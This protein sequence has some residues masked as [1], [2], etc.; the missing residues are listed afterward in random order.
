MAAADTNIVIT[1]FSQ[2]GEITWTGSNMEYYAVQYAPSV[3][4]TWTSSVTDL[5]SVPGHSGFHTVTVPMTSS[6]PTFYRIVGTP[7]AETGR[8]LIEGGTFPM[9]RS[10]DG[11]DAFAGGESSEQP[12]H[13]IV[14]DSFSL[15][16]R[17]VTVGEFRAFVQSGGGTQSQAPSQGDGANP[18]IPGSGWQSSWDTMLPFDTAALISGLKS[19]PVNG[20]WTDSAGA[21][22]GYPINRVTWHEAF[23]YCIWAGGRLPTEAEW[24]RAAAGGTDNRLYP[25]GSA[26]PDATRANYAGSDNTPFVDAGAKPAGAGKWWNLNMAGSMH[27][28]TLDWYD[29]GWYTNSPSTNP[30]NL[31]VSSARV[32]RGGGWNSS[33]TN[34]RAAARNSLGPSQRRSHVGFRLAH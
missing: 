21:N 30:A 23:A 11:S 26:V 28:W 32:I 14:L 2:N 8:A 27:E 33:I 6:V 16:M 29:P 12:E 20:T 5:E 15:G 34:L 1:S 22:E 4:N 13:D 24:E 10:S 31:N 19:D 3:D 9:G 25:W 7:G 18:N 17:P